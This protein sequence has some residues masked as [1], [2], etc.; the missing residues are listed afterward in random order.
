MASE[1][2]TGT[3]TDVDGE[4]SST[5]PL[6]LAKLYG[7]KGTSDWEEVYVGLCSVMDGVRDLCGGVSM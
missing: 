5:G 4:L 2:I 7:M 6:R 1:E 3:A